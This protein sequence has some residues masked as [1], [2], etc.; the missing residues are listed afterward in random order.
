MSCLIIQDVIERADAWRPSVRHLERKSGI[1]GGGAWRSSHI[2][3]KKDR[4]EG[5]KKK[6]D[7]GRKKGN[8]CCVDVREIL[9]D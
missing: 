4:K 3:L 2:E 9:I 5:T 7:G 6:K 8:Y 1:L